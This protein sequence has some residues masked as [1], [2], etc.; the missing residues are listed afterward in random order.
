MKTARVKQKVSELHKMKEKDKLSFELTIQRKRNIWDETRQSKLIHSILAGFLIPNLSGSRGETMLHIL[1]GN[2]R[3][4]SIFDYIDGKYKLVGVPNVDGVELKG[5]KFEKL[6]HDLKQRILDYKFEIDV[7]EDA[8]QEEMEEQFYRLNNGVPIRPIELIRADLGDSVLKFVERISSLPFFDKKVN[9]SKTAKRRFVDQ[10]LVLQILLLVQHPNTGF[11]S[12]EIRAFVKELRKGGVEDV[13]QAKMENA[14]AFLN[15]AFASDSNKPMTFLK[16][17]HVPMLLKLVLDLQKY[18]LEITP[19]QFAGWAQPFL[20]NPL[21][22][23]KEA[24]QSGS[25]RRE[26]VQRR[27]TVMREAFN[28][29]FKTQLE[30]DEVAA[31]AET[32]QK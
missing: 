32:V 31:A 24:S 6:T 29:H 1:D 20:E 5:K 3:L 15:E 11:S 26:N 13:L 8:T 23:Y 9:L 19:Q 28:A 14:S 4:S 27:L 2:Q 22:E 17:T 18:A 10:E 21:A 16:K 25:A 7:I 12:K 30:A